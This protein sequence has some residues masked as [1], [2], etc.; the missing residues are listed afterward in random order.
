VTSI[1]VLAL[2]SVQSR[3]ESKAQLSAA[4]AAVVANLD[5]QAGK[6]YDETIG[7]EFSPKYGE[8]F[9]NCKQ[10]SEKVPPSFDIFLKLDAQGKVTEMLAYPETAMA[11]CVRPALSSGKF[12]APPHGDYWVSIHL[13]FKK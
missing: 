11:Q 9:H 5:T 3:A 10:P 8:V 1:V 6:Q 2:F 7:K 4:M 12:S 13:Q